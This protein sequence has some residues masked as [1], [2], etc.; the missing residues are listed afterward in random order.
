[1]MLV[2]SLWG[3]LLVLLVACSGPSFDGT[4]V[5]AR[6]APNFTLLDQYGSDWTLSAQRGTDVALYFGYT[7]CPDD[8]P[9]TLAKLARAISLLHTTRAEIA[10][11][12]VDPSR[13]TPS[14][15]KA[16]LRRF[17]GAAIFGLTG[18]RAALARIY[19]A[20]GIWAQPHARN[21]RGG[22]DVAHSS[23]VFLIDARGMLRVV[24]FDSDPRSAFV[25]DLRVLGA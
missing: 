18:T 24:H 8:C 21:P 17:H 9:T 2:R 6:V 10:F 16:Y 13:D 1:M 7:H 23:P 11:V 12:T 20:Y 5:P 22:Y 25:H 19:R 4:S 15:F 3:C 14:R